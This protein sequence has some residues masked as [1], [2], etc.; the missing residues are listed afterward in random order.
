M[1]I[2]SWTSFLFPVG[3]HES[4]VSGNWKRRPTNQ[5]NLCVSSIDT[6][7]FLPLPPPAII[8]FTSLF[9]FP[10]LITFPIFYLKRTRREVA[11]EIIGYGLHQNTAGG[12]FSGRQYISSIP[13][14]STDSFQ[15]LARR[16]SV[17]LLPEL[18]AWLLFNWV[19]IITGDTSLASGRGRPW[20]W[21][22]PPKYLFHYKRAEFPS[23]KGWTRFKIYILFHYLLTTYLLRNNSR[24]LMY[25]W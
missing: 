13:F 1:Y 15:S 6:Y 25:F 2:Y 19:E 7:I 22:P 16:Y 14:R 3:G 17:M 9:L 8:S 23:V 21:C 5:V 10:R 4:V 12:Q 18:P 24:L 11:T 20:C